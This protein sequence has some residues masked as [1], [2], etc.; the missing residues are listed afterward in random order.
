MK[1]PET[2]SGARLCRLRDCRNSNALTRG[3]LCRHITADR[4]QGNTSGLG[5]GRAQANI[6]ILPRD[7]DDDKLPVFQTCSATP[8]SV[9]QASR[10]LSSITHASGCMWVSD[11]HS[12]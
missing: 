10:P 12:L 7:W 9:V 2:R 8:Q 1:I 5:P 6:V 3:A 11:R 4:Y